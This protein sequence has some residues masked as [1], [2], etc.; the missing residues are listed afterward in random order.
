MIRQALMGAVLTAALSTAAHA[1]DIYMQDFEDGLRA[2]ERIGSQYK[3]NNGNLRDGS[4]NWGVHHKNTNPY[5]NG[6]P[7][8]VFTG[9]VMGHVGNGGGGNLNYGNHERSFYEFTVDLSDW[10]VT[11]F[12]FNFDSWIEKDNSCRDGYNRPYICSEDGFNVVAYSGG[13]QGDFSVVGAEDL[14]LLNPLPNT[15]LQYDSGRVDSGG[16]L[17]EMTGFFERSTGHAPS[18][19]QGLAM[20]DTTALDSF[21]GLTT[22]RLSFGSDWHKEAEGV[23]I[24]NIMLQGNCPGSTSGDPNGPGAGCN[25]GG[26]PPGGVP[27]PGTLALTALGL[28]AL[29][30]RWKN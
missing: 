29:R 28:L 7:A 26:G 5:V 22:I 14:V 10:E 9:N 15:D 17:D 4:A 3:D 6:S 18:E 2:N 21:D 30:R 27:E 13:P 16:Q 19:M 8:G 24:D 11:T 1:A 12:K 25:P 23:N 20:F